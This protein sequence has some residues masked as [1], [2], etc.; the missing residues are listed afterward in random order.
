LAA[1]PYIRIIHTPQHLKTAIGVN[2]AQILGFNEAAG[3]EVSEVYYI[4]GT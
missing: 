2:A 3:M 1:S 4:N